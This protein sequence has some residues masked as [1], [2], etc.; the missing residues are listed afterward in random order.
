MRVASYRTGVADIQ[1]YDY[2]A[3]SGNFKNVELEIENAPLIGTLEKVLLDMLSY[4]YNYF[5][6]FDGATDIPLID[7]NSKKEY[8][9][10]ITLLKQK[11]N[12]QKPE[13]VITNLYKH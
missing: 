13:E 5:R 8:Y 2:I 10:N 9:N 3:T 4:T 7:S 12:G 1:V 11:F 6:N